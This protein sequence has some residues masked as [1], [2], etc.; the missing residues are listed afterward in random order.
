MSLARHGLKAD[1]AIRQERVEALRVRLVNLGEFV[2]HRVD[3]HGNRPRVRVEEELGRGNAIRE[4]AML[5][6]AHVLPQRPVVLRMRFHQIN[7]HKCEPSTPA[8]Q[9]VLNFLDLLAERWSGVAPGEDDER[10]LLLLRLRVQRCQRRGGFVE[11]GQRYINES[12]ANVQCARARQIEADV[13]QSSHE[14]RHF[15]VVAI[16]PPRRVELLKSSRKKVTI[17]GARKERDMKRIRDLREPAR[18]V[19]LVH[20]TLHLRRC[21]QPVGFEQKKF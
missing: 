4:R 2:L 10:L 7:S 13:F 5:Q 6:D 9:D 18:M 20:P 15:R 11:C 19:V 1:R 8:S 17:A 16:P 21:A 12:V 14:G 3:V